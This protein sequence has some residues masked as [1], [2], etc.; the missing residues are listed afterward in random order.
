MLVRCQFDIFWGSTGEVAA[1]LLAL[2]LRSG[3]ILGKTF[4]YFGIQ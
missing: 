1:V 4:D 3:V 2:L